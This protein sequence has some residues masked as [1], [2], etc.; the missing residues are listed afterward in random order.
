MI[1]LRNAKLTDS[2]PAIIAK[3]P[4][5][6]AMAFAVNNQMN[7]LLDYANG[8]LVSANVDT[9]PDAILDILAMEL[10]IPYYD[11]AYTTQVKRELIKGAIQYWATAGT[12]G[13][14]T[15]IME[16]IFGDAE[17]E[18]WFSYNGDPGNFRI[19]TTNPNVTGSTLEKFQETARHVKRLSAYL[20]EVIVDLGI[21]AMNVYQG[22]ALYHHTD[23]TLT[24]EG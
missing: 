22:N 4:W 14:L 20:E 9:M 15:E 21:P 6:Q 1:T 10:R 11:Q 19:I 13:S 24:Q 2:L 3:Q 16:N 8:V 23:I 12:V 17:I 18:E 5:A 7:R